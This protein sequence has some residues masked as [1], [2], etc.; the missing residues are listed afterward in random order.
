VGK[1]AGRKS[2]TYQ[3][4]AT[5]TKA[6]LKA[7]ADLRS[8]LVTAGEKK[9]SIKA[10]EWS[11]NPLAPL[12]RSGGKTKRY[13]VLPLEGG[14]ELA[15]AIRLESGTR[16]SR[17]V[18]VRPLF[19]IDLEELATLVGDKDDGFKDSLA[20]LAH[21]RRATGNEASTGAFAK[22][23]LESL[24]RRARRRT[25][26]SIRKSGA[27]LLD[28]DV[29][30]YAAREIVQLFRSVEDEAEREELADAYVEVRTEGLRL[31]PGPDL[32]YAQETELKDG[33]LTLT[34][35]FSTEKQLDA[36]HIDK[37]YDDSR[38]EWRKNQL[39]LT[40][41]ARLFRGAPF[42]EK[43][44]VS[45]VVASKGYD[46]T[47]PNINLALW[48]KDGQTI[49][50]IFKSGDLRRLAERF[51]GGRRGDD[52]DDDRKKSTA[53]IALGMGYKVDFSLD[54]ISRR[55]RRFAEGLLPEWLDEPSFVLFTGEKG[56]P[57]HSSFDDDSIWHT[58]SGTKM[59]GGSF[60]FG[61]LSSGKNFRWSV[62][63][64]LLPY[65]KAENI[66]RVEVAEDQSGSVT[67]FTNDSTVAFRKIEVAGNLN[68]DWISK[69]A[70]AI[71]KKERKRLGGL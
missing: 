56:K 16:K 68:V 42:V 39:V 60:K 29:W 11:S 59:R 66:S 30:T 25:V 7:F 54:N 12:P 36:F 23:N 64:S 28:G 5:E 31:D 67:F 48:T 8:A 52:D 65:T 13:R 38:I 18:E 53:Y 63:S 9:T 22:I 26:E 19:S 37:D 34:Y 46:P 21:F 41:E 2:A 61:A 3:S 71:A 24:R 6:I 62:G 51:R 55:Y 49:S 15:A 10:L 1:V 33:Y 50:G 17:V 32:F 70:R 58:P 35:D 45:G 14:P 47:A 20:T 69:Q 57:L 4:L 44:A 40:G 27:T 43:I